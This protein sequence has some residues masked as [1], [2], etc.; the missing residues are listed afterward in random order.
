MDIKNPERDDTF[1]HNKCQRNDLRA[2][3]ETLYCLILHS[4]RVF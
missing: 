3:S 1:K 2:C 4:Y